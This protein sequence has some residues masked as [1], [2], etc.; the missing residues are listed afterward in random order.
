MSRQHTR[1]LNAN[2]FKLGLFGLN[3]SGGITM[4]RA[5]ERWEPDW[6]SSVQAA[7]LADAAGLEFLLP[8]ARWLGHA[9]QEGAEGGSLET[10]SWASGLLAA[11][12]EIVAFATVHT[13][14][15][16][17]IFAAKQAVTADQI[18]KGRFGLNVVSGW[19]AAEFEMFGLEL[20]EHD[21]R[22]THTEEWLTIVRRLWSEDEPFDFHGR[23]YHLT[24]AAGY[25]K[26]YWGE[27]PMIMSAGS[28]PTGRAFAARE[29]DC[30]FMVIVSLDALAEEV[31]A[32]R[33]LAESRRVGV[34]ASGHLYCRPTPKET[35]E[36]FHYIVHEH[37]DWEAAANATVIRRNSR[38][39]P[40]DRLAAMK[41]R[42]VAGAGTFPVIGSPDQVAAT[43]KRLSDAGL[44]GMAL[45]LPNYVNDMKIV[46]E[47][48]LPRLER[49]GLR[50]PPRAS[51][52]G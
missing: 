18:G 38:S 50:Q 46:R 36:Y 10:L 49:L 51:V 15:V 31:S 47:E 12:Q 4:T 43:F 40:A 6:D 11:T 25:P 32:I 7:R 42:F 1:I 17:P 28:S 45:G 16:H 5:P 3:C 27:R 48:V 33:A 37:G 20:R 22:Y 8:V 23:Y 9:G 2:R 26:P 52:P 13:P 39:I 34:F 14:L 41:E 44:D 30:L 35:E 29:A 19:H 21:E 24:G